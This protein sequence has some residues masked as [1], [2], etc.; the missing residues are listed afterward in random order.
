MITLL[1]LTPI[2]NTSRCQFKLAPVMVI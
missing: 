1:K 2:I